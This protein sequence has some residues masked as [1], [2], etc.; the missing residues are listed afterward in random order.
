VSFESDRPFAVKKF[1]TFL[2]EEVS[3]AVFRAKGILWF[4][5]SEARHVFQLSGPRYDLNQEDWLEP[6][7]NQLVLIGRNLDTAK[8]KAQLTACLV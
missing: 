2:T 6:P 5:E 1:E 8:L 7:K 3:T 4:Q